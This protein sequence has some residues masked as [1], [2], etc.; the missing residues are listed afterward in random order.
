MSIQNKKLNIVSDTNFDGNKITDAKINA[1]ENTISNLEVSNFKSGVVQTVVRDGTYATDTSVPTEKA[2]SDALDKKQDGLPEQ[3]SSAGKYLT[4]DGTTVSWGEVNANYL[5]DTKVLSQAISNKGWAYQCKSVRTDLAKADI[6]TVY[7]DIENKYLNVDKELSAFQKIS[8]NKND[9]AFKYF[10]NDTTQKY[11]YINTGNPYKIYSSITPNLASTTLEYT[12][13]N[14]CNCLCAGNN[15]IIVARYARRIDNVLYFD[16]DIFDKNLTFLRQITINAGTWTRNIP[17]INKLWFR[18][19]TFIC[20]MVAS[21][22]DNDSTQWVIILKDNTNITSGYIYRDFFGYTWRNSDVLEQDHCPITNVIND[23]YVYMLTN[24]RSGNRRIYKLDLDTNELTLCGSRPNGS[25]YTNMCYYNNKFYVAIHISYHL[26]F[27]E[28]VD[29]SSWTE[30]TMFDDENIGCIINL[31]SFCLCFGDYNVYSTTDFN[32]F[33]VY[34]SNISTYS[35][36]HNYFTNYIQSDDY[37]F[38]LCNINTSGT[39]P[40]NFFGSS[41]IP[42]VY[43]DNYTINGSTIS[44]QYYKNED[45]KICIAGENGT[46]DVNLDTVFNGLGYLNYWRLD[47][48]GQTVTLPRNSNLYTQMFVGDN[49]DDTEDNLI[50]ADWSATALKS[51]LDII[52]DQTGNSG[53]F[54]T[55]DGSTLSWAEV[56]GGT[57]IR[58]VDYYELAEVDDTTDITGTIEI[59]KDIYLGEIT[60]DRVVKSYTY[61]GSVW[62]NDSN[63]TVSLTTL[64]IDIS[65]ATYSLNSS[66]DVYSVCLRNKTSFTMSRTITT[67]NCLYLNGNLQLKKDYN[68]TTTEI[69]GQEFPTIE[70]NDYTLKSTDSISII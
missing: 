40:Y 15:I 69:D 11:Y 62:K 68:V 9:T 8:I 4:T 55:T 31:G 21:Y 16:F 33:T 63:D 22:G 14:G 50:V 52:P 70:F 30:I 12:G 43:T 10:Y 26:R 29:C 45:W 32:T 25:L 67:V 59:D 41:L 44:I 58:Q 38:V 64:G 36:L 7:E 20:N 46:D 2:V 1:Q 60:D 13:D 24:S 3:S 65:N 48:N 28:S 6:P 23:K 53:K 47:R 34:E 49:Y 19:D 61:D 57:T 27:Y 56:Q 51:E 5:Y 37:F 17:S 18:R 35:S 39:A 66:F 54:L 42:K